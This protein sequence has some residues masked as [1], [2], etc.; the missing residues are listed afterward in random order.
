MRNEA[1]IFDVVT[2]LVWGIRR[3]RVKKR[4]EHL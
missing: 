1:L 2:K 3:G 4:A